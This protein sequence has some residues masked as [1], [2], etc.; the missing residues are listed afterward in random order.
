MNLQQGTAWTRRDEHLLRSTY[1]WLPLADIADV[2]GRS[3]V[4]IRNRAKVLGIKRHRPKRRSWTAAEENILRREYPHRSTKQLSNELH[5]PIYA[6]YQRA[7]HLGLKKTA[8]YM[9]TSVAIAFIRPGAGGERYRFPKGHVPANKGSRRP[10]YAPGRMAETQFK[11]GM[12]PHTWVPVGTVK[13]RD[14]YLVRKIADVPQ[15][16]AGI[17]ALSTNWEYVHIRTWQD[18]HGPIPAGHAVVFK[19]RNSQHTEIENLE[20]VTRSELM[21]RN[22]IHHLPAALKQLIQLTGALKRKIRNREKK[23]N[24]EEHIAGSAGSPVHGARIAV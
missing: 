8:E 9:K 18:A 2:L 6:L 3:T 14:G 5:R 16:I 7:R 11:K 4:A 23:Q 20:L 12:R 22:T 24:G 21:R 19:D 15:S 1:P 13:M 17:G 10:G